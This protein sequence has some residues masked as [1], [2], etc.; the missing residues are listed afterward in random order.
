MESNTFLMGVILPKFFIVL[1]GG[2]ELCCQH[3]V[4]SVCD[5]TLKERFPQTKTKEVH[6]E[7]AE[8]RSFRRVSWTNSEF[9]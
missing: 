9:L 6:S 4:L 8:K 5:P 2:D 1:R 3:V 7:E